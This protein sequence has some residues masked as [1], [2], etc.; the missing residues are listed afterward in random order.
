MA[1]SRASAIIHCQLCSSMVTAYYTLNERCATYQTLQ[2]EIG[3]DDSRLNW[4]CFLDLTANSFE[5]DVSFL[6]QIRMSYESH[7]EYV[8]TSLAYTQ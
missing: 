6:K 8:L 5:V 7:Y 1:L 3:Y 2:V 4:G